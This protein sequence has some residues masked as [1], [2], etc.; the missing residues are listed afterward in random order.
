MLLD[1][2]T[3]CYVNCYVSLD[4]VRYVQWKATALTRC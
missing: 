1:Y 2:E 3:F 4:G